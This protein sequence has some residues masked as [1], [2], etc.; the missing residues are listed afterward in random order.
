MGERSSEEGIYVSD[1][2]HQYSDAHVETLATEYQLGQ[3][4]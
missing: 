2:S 3:Q 4:Y 1:A